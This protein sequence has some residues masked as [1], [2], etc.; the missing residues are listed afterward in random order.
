MAFS[1]DNFIIDRALGGSMFSPANGDLL[2]TIDQ[3]ENPDM[4]C[5]STTDEVTDALGSTIAIFNR[6]KKAE[7]T[8]TNSLFNLGLAAGQFGATKNIASAGN[9]I[10]T[11]KIEY[12]TTTTGQT[13]IVL[14]QIPVGV[15]GAEIKSINGIS[16]TA[17]NST[18]YSVAAAASATEFKLD[19]A[20]K[21]ITLPTGLA[22]GTKIFVKYNYA[23]QTTTEI[24]NNATEFPTAGEFIMQ[25]IGHLGCDKATVYVANVVMPNAELKSEVDLKFESKGKHPFTI[26][27]MQD[28]CDS[29]KQLFRIDIDAN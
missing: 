5:T 28:F 26:E 2:W 9:T 14:A 29:N 23:S 13:T 18:K 21:T 11:P 6:A 10:V 22:V 8:G 24:A 7:F 4:K 1:Y 20:T 27:A 12:F 25:V 17:F 3:I 19:A 16:G 15:T